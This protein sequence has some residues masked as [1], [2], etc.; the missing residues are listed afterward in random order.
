[1][2]EIVRLKSMNLECVLACC[3]GALLGSSTWEGGSGHHSHSRDGCKR[4]DS[5]M[6][7]I[8][9]TDAFFECGS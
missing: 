2:A 5:P 1:M 3:M 7:G 6:H 4:I 8:R 9:F